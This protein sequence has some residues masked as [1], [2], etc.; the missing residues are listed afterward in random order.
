MLYIIYLFLSFSANLMKYA[1]EPKVRR[2]NT[3]HEDQKSDSKKKVKK[4]SSKGHKRKRKALA[5]EKVKTHEP[6]HR[7]DS[8]I[9]KRSLK[10]STAPKDLRIE[11][12]EGKCQRENLGVK[13]ELALHDYVNLEECQRLMAL[14]E[15]GNLRKPGS[16]FPNII[17]YAS[18][19]H[20]LAMYGNPKTPLLPNLK[21]FS[22]EHLG[23]KSRGQS[24]GQHLPV[25]IV[26]P[27]PRYTKTVSSLDL[28]PSV[29]EQKRLFRLSAPTGTPSAHHDINQTKQ[30][31]MSNPRRGVSNL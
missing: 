12:P 4:S 29:Q 9:R 27:Q 5:A 13:E 1:E 6:D 2:V 8:L 14:M 21:F 15:A 31:A 30:N 28:R 25:G 11:L 3:P 10:N 16:E 23:G 18:T 17:G 26:N 22:T 24:L 20:I 7:P 19:Q